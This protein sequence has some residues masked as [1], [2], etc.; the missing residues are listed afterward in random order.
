MLLSHLLAHRIFVFH[1]FVIMLIALSGGADSVALLLK[2]QEEGRVE[3]AAH[4][5][6]HLRGAESDRDEAF[7]RN[8]CEQYSV[9]L[10]VQHFDTVSEAQR[11]GE[12]I[13][14]AARRL[15][16]AWFAQ[17]CEQYHFDSVAVAHHRDDNAETFLLHLVR[18]AGLHGL[19]GMASQRP[20]V[21]RPLLNWSRQDVLDYLAR[22]QQTY[23]TDSTNADTRY[24]RNLL[25]H[26]VLPL[27]NQLNPQV[28]QTIHATAQRLTEA[29]AIYRYGVNQLQQQLCHT[30]AH[31]RVNLFIADLTAAPS[32]TTLLYEWLSPYGFTPHQV[33]E[34]LQLRVGGVLTAGNYLLTRT[35]DSLQWG[36]IP[37]PFAPLSLKGERGEVILPEGTYVKWE[38]VTRTPDFV[39]PRTSNRVALDAEI[40]SGSLQLRRVAS[41]DRFVPFGMKGSRLMSDYLTD[42]HRSRLEKQAACVVTDSNG[43]VWLVGERPAQRVA[44]TARTR[45]VLLLT[46]VH[47]E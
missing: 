10:F 24:Q 28:A 41:A 38:Y 34:V 18:G 42:R 22:R 33:A 29:E 31:G 21:V 19:T 9:R 7:V 17:L 47:H 43:I 16:Y 27:L 45:Q 25:R 23:V 26:E 6:F 35:R 32:P 1:L 36:R 5:N 44:V 12:S 13:E 14:M 2:M 37:Q 20:G 39:L 46:L 40:L 4:C 30:D 15:R 8:L 3:A 11:T